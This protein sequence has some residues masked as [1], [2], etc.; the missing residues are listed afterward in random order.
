[1]KAKHKNKTIIY[2][3]VE[4]KDYQPDYGHCIAYGL[5]AIYNCDGNT[6]TAVVIHNITYD[7]KAAKKLAFIFNKFELSIIHFMDAVT[8]FLAYPFTF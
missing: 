1:M 6:E 4:E 8:D 7:H 3:V 5:M 2:E